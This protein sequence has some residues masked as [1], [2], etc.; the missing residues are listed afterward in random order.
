MGSRQAGTR[1]NRRAKPRDTGTREPLYATTPTP[2]MG[3]TSE[4]TRPWSLS[5]PIR[6]VAEARDGGEAGKP[7]TPT[8]EDAAASLATSDDEQTHQVCE[9]LR[10]GVGVHHAGVPLIARKAVEALAKAGALALVVATEGLGLGLNLSVSKGCI[11][12]PSLFDAESGMW[13]ARSLAHMLQLA[14]RFGRMDAP[15][16]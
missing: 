15:R 9:L 1:A 4:E 11:V 6:A 8:E 13:E 5:V 7:A 3:P 16:V 12:D 14:G 10:C 2:R